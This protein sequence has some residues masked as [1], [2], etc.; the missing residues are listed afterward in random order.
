[1]TRL[2]FRHSVDIEERKRTLWALY[3]QNVKASCTFGRPPMLRLAD[4]GAWRLFFVCRRPK[5]APAASLTSSFALLRTTR[6][7]DL[8]EPV[9]VDD[10]YISAETGIGVQPL[11]R[12]SIMAGF[13]AAIRL[14]M[15]LER[16]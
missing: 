1:L 13:V 6:V 4:L 3:C 9:A 15:V 11:D 14:H 12:P 16:T 7:A 8:D 5:R 10:I 2:P